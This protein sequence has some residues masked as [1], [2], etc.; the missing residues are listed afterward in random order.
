MKLIFTPEFKKN[1]KKLPQK[2]KNRVNKQLRFLQ[3]DWRYPSL[4]VKK[5][6]GSKNKW[7]ARVTRSYR[8]R[9]LPRKNKTFMLSVGPHDEGLGKK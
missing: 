1:Y 7:E 9:F 8:M 3:K 5:M 4:R 2:L 6:R